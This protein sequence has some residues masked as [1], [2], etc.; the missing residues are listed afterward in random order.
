[1]AP[2]YTVVLNVLRT[3]AVARQDYVLAEKAA[4][5]LAH[6]LAKKTRAQIVEELL[7]R[8]REEKASR[9]ARGLNHWEEHGP[10][11]LARVV[12]ARWAAH[13]RAVGAYIAANHERLVGLSFRVTQD[14]E[15]ARRATGKTYIEL[16]EGK[17]RIDGAEYAV[18]MNSR[19]ELRLRKCE[20]RKMR[21]IE[22]LRPHADFAGGF[23]AELDPVDF[24]SERR[25][26]RDPLELLIEKEEL[27]AA[28][29][30]VKNDWRYRWIKQ[31]E[32]GR[33]LELHA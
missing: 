3:A 2:E 10:T 28:K 26:D 30:V 8:M 17:A 25:E 22:E 29:A 18:I 21:S 16:L 20:R 4:G 15:L 24:P 1:M 12:T 33:A 32:W 31:K 14:K 5:Y 23:E 19:D 7:S 27:D 6:E 13:R 11:F 9:D